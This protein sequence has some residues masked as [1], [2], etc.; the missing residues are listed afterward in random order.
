MKM[1]MTAVGCLLPALMSNAG[2]QQPSGRIDLDAVA[3]AS[4]MVTARV[5]FTKSEA[6]C[7]EDEAILRI[8]GGLL[9]QHQRIPRKARFQRVETYR[10][11]DDETYRHRIATKDCRL[12]IVVRQQVYREDDAWVSLLVPRISRPSLSLDERQRLQRELV[13]RLR[14][15]PTAS[16]ARISSALKARGTTGSLAQ[17]G[18]GIFSAGAKFEDAP[19][20]CVEAIGNYAVDQDGITFFFATGLPGNLN[21][22]VIER[23]DIDDDHSRLYLTGADCRFEITV[24][25]DVLHNDTW[26]ARSIAPVTPSRT[27]INIQRNPDSRP[28]WLD[29]SD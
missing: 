5:V 9:R 1:R 4:A 27:R 8:S 17:G 21:R 14:S 6:A 7:P 23:T 29:R 10:P 19:V 24:G 16:D 15:P 13:D 28:P 25:A 18:G 22:F 26:V 20:T 11:V 2:A 12:D 3:A